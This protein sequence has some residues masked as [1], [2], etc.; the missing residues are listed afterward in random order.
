MRPG[1]AATFLLVCLC[2]VGAARAGKVK[3]LKGPADDEVVAAL[4]KVR[5]QMAVCWQRKPPATVTIN[6]TVAAS[7][8]VT[9]ATAKTKGTAAQCAAGILAVSTLAPSAKKWSGAVQITT[10]SDKREIGRAS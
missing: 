2:H 3:L 5:G 6:L 4:E 7:G 1:I 10:A 9:K 8:E